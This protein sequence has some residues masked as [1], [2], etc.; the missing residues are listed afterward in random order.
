MIDFGNVP[1]KMAGWPLEVLLK[2]EMLSCKL[3]G[4]YNGRA[5]VVQRHEEKKA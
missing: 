3:C 2:P 1:L 4:R 5:A